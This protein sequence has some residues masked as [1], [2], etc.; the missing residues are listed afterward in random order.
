MNSTIFLEGMRMFKRKLKIKRKGFEKYSGNDVEI[1]RKIISDCYNKGKKYFQVSAGKDSNYPE[2]YSRDFGWCVESL[3]NLGYKKEVLNT[4]K[5]SLEI[6]SDKKNKQGITVAINPRGKTFNF[7]NVY[8]PDSTAYFFRSLRVAGAKDL[9]LKYS[10]FLN[11]EIKKF[12]ETA[13]DKEKGIVNGKHFSG[14]RD[15]S[16]VNASCYDMIMACSLCDEIDKINKLVGRN[17]LNNRLTK[18][19]LKKK[20]IKYYWTGKYFRNTP[21]DN[22]LA[23]HNN[24]YPFFLDIIKDKKILKSC[25]CE[26]IKYKYDEPFPLKYEKRKT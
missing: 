5:Y 24:V 22:I 2:F 25:I 21:D 11:R 18:Y 15:H 3:I 1:C 19:L 17:I 26:L 16:I 8:S 9:I 4:L 6:Y 12:E 13:I 7:P 20:L 10:D 23:G 14:M